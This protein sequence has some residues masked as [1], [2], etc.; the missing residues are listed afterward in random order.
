MMDIVGSL[1][2]VVVHKLGS[3]ALV[4]VGTSSAKSGVPP[5]LFPV[6]G[7]VTYTNDFGQARSGGSHQ[8]N[9]LMAT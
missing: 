2:S 6:V 1:Q 7:P 4:C 8:G 9:D 3:V 5:L